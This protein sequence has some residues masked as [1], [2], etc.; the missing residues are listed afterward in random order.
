MQAGGAAGSP[1]WI[2]V[3]LSSG[4]CRLLDVRSGNIIASWQAH[5]GYVTKVHLSI[6]LYKAGRIST[7]LRLRRTFDFNFT[8]AIF[9]FS[10]I[11]LQQD[12]NPNY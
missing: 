4:I 12:S 11:C 5:D 3:G 8:F 9:F 10:K 1:S 2:A 7:V 6:L